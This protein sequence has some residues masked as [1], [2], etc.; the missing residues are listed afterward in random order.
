M[1]R[2]WAIISRAELLTEP[3]ACPS[4]KLMVLLPPATE[5]LLLAELDHLRTFAMRKAPVVWGKNVVQ[6]VSGGD[7]HRRG[8]GQHLFRVD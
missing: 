2:I 8:V 1:D 6:N 7:L 5:E 4:A 3:G